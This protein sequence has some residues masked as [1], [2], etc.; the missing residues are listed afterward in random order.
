MYNAGDA[1]STKEPALRDTTL[2]GY[3]ILENSR[4]GLP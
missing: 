4:R 3:T 1:V 2:D